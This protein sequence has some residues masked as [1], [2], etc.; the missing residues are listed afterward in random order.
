VK[1][2]LGHGYQYAVGLQHPVDSLTSTLFQ[3]KVQKC[4]Q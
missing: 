1:A 4:T 3:P 2:V